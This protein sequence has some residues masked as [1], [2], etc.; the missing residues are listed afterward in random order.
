MPTTAGL[1]T[2]Y[3]G[4]AATTLAADAQ[5]PLLE[6]HHE[7]TSTLDRAHELAA[8]GAPAGTVVVANRQTA[9]R[10]RHGRV[11]QSASGAG[12]WMTMV[13]RPTDLQAL[14]V[15]SL[16]LGVLLADALAPFS[17]ASIRLKWPNDLWTDAGKL[18]GTLVEARWRGSA[19]EWVAIGI[20][21]NVRPADGE[22]QTTALDAAVPRASVLA[23]ICRAARRAA[24]MRGLLSDDEVAAWVAR[25]LA[26]GRAVVEPTAGVVRGLRADG[27]LL[28]ETPSGVQGILSGSLRFAR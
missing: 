10:G 15:L 4:V 28:V 26:C 11:W 22:P 3:D 5:V 21:V 27:A 25:D 7:L 2:A 14:G 6:L 20:G 19:L 18:A 13:E 24:A 8:E 17:A 16:R 23:V 1:L 12:V 9:G